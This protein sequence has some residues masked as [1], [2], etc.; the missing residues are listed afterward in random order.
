MRH[1][2]SKRSGFS[3]TYR[4]Y[5]DMLTRC[6]REGSQ[7]YDNYGGRGIKVCKRWLE[8]FDNFLED[9]GE[10]PS[11]FQLDRRDNN[12]NYTLSNC[13]WVTPVEN[14][15]NR[16]MTKVVLFRGKK[17]CL[18][19]LVDRYGV[20]DYKGTWQRLKRGWGVEDA[21]FRKKK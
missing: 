8:S 15:R 3:P 2:H 5:R 21:L 9:M 12:G 7:Q 6:M 16:R 13:R 14:S 4:S 1:G 19:S 18:A 20:L 11:G 17:E 10:K